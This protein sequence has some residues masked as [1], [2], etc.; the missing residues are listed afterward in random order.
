V[1]N[2]IIKIGDRPL[3]LSSGETIALTRQAAKVGDFVSVMADG[4]NEVT[5]PLTANNK[6]VLDNAHIFGTDSLIPYRRT[7]AT[8]IQEGYETITNGFSIVKSSADNFSLQIVGGNG[9]FFDLIRNLNLRQLDL[10]EYSHF[11]TNLNAF[12]N[13]NNT[14]GYVY[15]VFEQSDLEGVDS[16]M[17]TYGT[18]LYA[19]QTARLLPSF[20][21]KTLIG[22]IF[23]EQGYTFVTDLVAEDIYTNLIVFNGMPN[24]GEDMSHH[25]CTVV[26]DVVIFPSFLGSRLFQYTSVINGTLYTSDAEFNSRLPLYGMLAN[27]A[28]FTLTDPCTVTVEFQL[29]IG[30]AYYLLNTDFTINV[31]AT[32][33]DGFAV[34]ASN[35]ITVN[36][37]EY[38]PPYDGEVTLNF[39]MTFDVG[40]FNGLILFRPGV[41]YNPNTGFYIKAGSSYTVT[42]AVMLSNTDITTSFPYNYFNGLV[43]VP[44]LKQGDFLKDMAKVFQWIYDVNEVTKVVTAR[45]YDSVQENI[46]TAIDMSDK[47]D[48]RKQKITYGIDGFAQTNSLAYKPDDITNYDAIGYINVDDQTLKAESNYVEVSAFAA[49]STR[50]RF[51][52][53]A[54]PYVPI[55]DVD[56]MPNNG[57]THRLLLTKR[58]DPFPYN[59]NFNRATEAPYDYSTD[60]LTFAYFA[61]AGNLD[62]LDFPNLI[63]RF[64]QTVM[65]ISYRGKT[66]ECLMNLKISDVVNYNPFIPVYIS[67]HGS[68]FYWQKVSNYVKDKLTKCTFIRL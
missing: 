3:D 21:I 1:S 17:R 18:N 45:R 37:Y 2:L 9:G 14:D 4:T 16:T 64:Y 55:F 33:I 42:N 10:V 67:Q 46:P 68:Y 7:D 32:T 57:V 65:A 43:P 13:R 25:L 49:T 35:T 15:A 23:G 59:V 24:R 22:K 58:V 54:A 5:I 44:D 52:S 40:D 30:F 26:N 11:W 8:M 63:N 28:G 60:D 50:Q 36:A 39:T 31:E 29:I 20:H 66:L 61:E 12:D 56:I 19:V 27:D 47:I 62:S 48:T 38:T 51:D 6:A 53:V 41:L 34:Y